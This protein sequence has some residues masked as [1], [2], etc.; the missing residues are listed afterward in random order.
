MD[1]YSDPRRSRVWGSTRSADGFGRKAHLLLLFPQVVIASRPER[2]EV[3]YEPIPGASA[4]KTDVAQQVVD[5]VR[6]IGSDEVA[7]IA[8]RENLVGPIQNTLDL[9]VHF[10][11]TRQIHLT[12]ETLGEPV[13]GNLRRQLT[14]ICHNS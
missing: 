13:C 5:V 9:P 11:D 2:S 12:A 10:I 14:V 6:H 4:G 8:R 7:L 3:L 1:N